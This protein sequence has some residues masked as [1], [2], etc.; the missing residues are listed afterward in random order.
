MNISETMHE[1]NTNVVT[2]HANA[3]HTIVSILYTLFLYIKCSLII[4][5]RYLFTQQ[6]V[7]VYVIYTVYVQY[8]T[9]RTWSIFRDT[10]MAI[11]HVPRFGYIRLCIDR[12]PIWTCWVWIRSRRKGKRKKY[13]IL[14]KC[15]LIS[16]FCRLQQVVSSLDTLKR[17][18][19]QSIRQVKWR[20]ETS[21]AHPEL[22]FR[23]LYL[24]CFN[25]RCT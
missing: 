2:K 22:R 25:V 4:N 3:M 16:L 7:Y 8:S 21:R 15:Q 11:Q 5:N 10:T 12:I 6:Y 18:A 17:T 24:S 20:K 13:W 9:V 23:T 19:S 14:S 1:M